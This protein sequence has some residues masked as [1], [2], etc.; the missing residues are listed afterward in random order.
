MSGA[1]VTRGGMTTAR[2]CPPGQTELELQAESLGWG[3]LP[4]LSLV[5]AIG[6]GLVV[7]AYHGGRQEAPWSDGLRWIGLSVLYVPSAI[8][9]LGASASRRERQGLVLALGLGFYLVRALYSPLEPKFP[10]E[11]QHWRSAQNILESGRLFQANPILPVSSFYPGLASVTSA[12]STVSGLPI[13]E[14]GMLIMCTARI[15]FVLALY[16]FFER[17]SR[18][19]RVAGVASLV[20]MA[21]PHYQSFAA[22][23][24]YQSLALPLTAVV[25]YYSMARDQGDEQGRWA[26]RVASLVFLAA[27]TATH[28]LTSFFMAGFMLLWTIFV[29]CLRR[30]RPVGPGWMALWS[31]AL[32]LAWTF[33]VAPT[34]VSY[35]T[36]PLS[37][38]L[39]ELPQFAQVGEGAAN[40][41]RV[42]ANSP[43]EQGLSMASAGVIVLGLSLGAWQIWRKHRGSA[44]ALAMA[45][46]SLSYYGT[47]VLRL[48]SRGAELAGRSWVFI[49]L[50]VAFTW[51]AGIVETLNS[52]S[53][54]LWHVLAMLGILMIY[55]GG[56]ASGWP[57]KW[58][59]LPGPYQVGAFERS[60]DPEGVAAAR[61]AKQAL[62]SNSRIA[63]DFIQY[64]LLGAYGGQ[65]PVS[66]LAE[67]YLA[68]EIGPEELEGLQYYDIR[69]VLVDR[70]LGRVLPSSGFYFGFGSHEQDYAEP[71]DLLALD[72]FDHLPGVRRIL[73]TGDIVLYDVGALVD[74]P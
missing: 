43:M 7:W 8:R 3:W 70:R 10:D 61:W 34:T 36:Q 12:L 41:F 27:V 30:I 18:S 6:L 47:L 50:V 9:M 5:M 72:K 64:H 13:F 35:L 49:F 69:Y 42:S 73:D 15:V 44:V 14:A 52:R 63:A 11:L 23:F 67:V 71:L 2:A 4:S 25:L 65:D 24:I 17:A 60:V 31:V 59:R 57:P 48:T 68:P 46:A 53:S 62:P 22:M 29:F 1:A 39:S 58:G 33:G 51:A 28:H 66:S 16:L 40:T 38:A 74:E 45:T 20:Y 56:I 32:V 54:R 55:L 21:N 26:R 37:N 19:A